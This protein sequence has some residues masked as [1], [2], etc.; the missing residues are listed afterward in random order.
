MGLALTLGAFA[1][2]ALVFFWLVGVVKTT[3]KTAF[4]VALF[5]LGLWLAFGIGPSQI[6]ETIRN[7][8][9][10]FLFPS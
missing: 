3:I 4:L 9:P 8:L 7:W 10:D 6:W 5:L 1:I 2:A